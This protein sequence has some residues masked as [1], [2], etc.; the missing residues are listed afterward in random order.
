MGCTYARTVPS[1]ALRCLPGDSARN[2]VP[3]ASIRP[4]R[5]SSPY[6]TRVAQRRPIPRRTDL[7]GVGSHRRARRVL[8]RHA[9]GRRLEDDKRGGDVVPDLRLHQGR[10]V[11][12]R[13]GGSALGPKRDLRRHGRPEFLL[14]RAGRRDVQVLRCRTQLASHRP[15]DHCDSGSPTRPERCPGCR[16]GRL[17]SD[18]ERR[19]GR[20]PLDRRRRE[21]GEDTVRRRQDRHRNARPRGRRARR[22][23]SCHYVPLLRAR[24]RYLIRAEDRHGA[25]PHAALQVPGRWVDLA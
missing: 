3:G 21:L 10:L 8:R 4:C 18:P 17:L 6:G 12:R 13:R 25:D 23:P 24:D 1:G 9:R 22:H 20:L 5:S 2:A 19:P 15:R 16:T 14:R 11:H 7:R